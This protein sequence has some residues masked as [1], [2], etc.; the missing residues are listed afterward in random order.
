[1]TEKK[2]MTCVK[3]CFPLQKDQLK[4]W[5]SDLGGT[6]FSS[7]NHRPNAK[8]HTVVITKRHIEDLRGLTPQEWADILPVL[9]ESIAKVDKVYRPVGYFLEIPVGKLSGENEPPHFYM[10]VVPKYKKYWGNVGTDW[11]GGRRYCTEENAKEITT[12]LQ[13]DQNRVIAE[14][15]KI[16][17]K[18]YANMGITGISTKAHLPNDIQAIDQE[19]WAEIGQMLQEL[20]KKME[21]KKVCHDFT[22]K[23]WLRE[24]WNLKNEESKTPSAFVDNYH[25]SELVVGLFP[26]YKLQRWWL[27]NEARPT[28]KKISG[29]MENERI[30]EKLRNPEEYAKIWGKNK[31]EEKQFKSNYLLYD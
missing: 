18:L 6:V 2:C 15:S 23:I 25:N 24:E 27:P 12:A 29:T 30:A 5:L 31:I 17:A 11:K 14:K 8:A 1:M 16:V 13:P 9:K 19:T 28:D 22:V 10:R 3:A 26:R 7:V 20:M 21:D 4:S